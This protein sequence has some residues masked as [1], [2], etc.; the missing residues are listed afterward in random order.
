MS[1]IGKICYTINAN[2]NVLDN[3]ICIDEFTGKNNEV[4]YQLKNQGNMLIL[5]ERC[6]F[7]NR[8]DALSLI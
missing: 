2:K 4:L 3:W 8:K 5:P 6:V 7:F 1:K